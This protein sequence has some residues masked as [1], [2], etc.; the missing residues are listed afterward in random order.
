M[1]QLLIDNNDSNFNA[2]YNQKF[3]VIYNAMSA[4]N[5]HKLHHEHGNRVNIFFI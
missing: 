1:I 2:K 3:S 5:S 4:G